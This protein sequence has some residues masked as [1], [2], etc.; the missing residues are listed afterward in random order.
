MVVV[1]EP[2]LSSHPDT[3]GWQHMSLVPGIEC[4]LYLISTHRLTVSFA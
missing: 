3:S 1:V 4:R 2:V